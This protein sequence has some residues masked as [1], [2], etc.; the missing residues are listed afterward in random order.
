MSKHTKRSSEF[1]LKL[2]REKLQGGSYTGVSKKWSVP[3]TQLKKWVDQ[4]NLLGPSGLLRRSHQVY[5]TAFKIKVIDGHYKKGL[6]LRDCCSVY[7]IPTQSTVVSWLRKYDHLGISGLER[8]PGRPKVMKEN[9]PQRKQSKQPTRLEELEKE[10]LYLR[11]ENE[12]LKKLEALTQ[13]RETPPK[14]KR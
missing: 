8:R 14:K 2:V 7:N 10:N 4:Y 9:E 5:S 13:K 6:S 3:R 11:A 1:K 12:L